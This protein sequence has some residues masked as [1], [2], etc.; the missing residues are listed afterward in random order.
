M[1]TPEVTADEI[2]P[3]S[4]CVSSL[5]ISLAEVMSQ[6]KEDSSLGVLLL[7]CC[8]FCC[9]ITAACCFCT[10]DSNDESTE[11]PPALRHSTKEGLETTI[12]LLE[13]LEDCCGSEQDFVSIGLPFCF[14]LGGTTIIFLSCT[15]TSVIGTTSTLTR[16]HFPWASSRL[17]NSSCELF[18]A[19]QC[20]SFSTTCRQKCRISLVSPCVIVLSSLDTTSVCFNQIYCIHSHRGCVSLSCSLPVSMQK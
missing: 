5:R 17:H 18:N 4:S 13:L 3:L 2:L 16:L 12:Q 10:E 20:P 7:K 11:D 14:S 9:S 1:I 15:G 8:F 19:N 6:D